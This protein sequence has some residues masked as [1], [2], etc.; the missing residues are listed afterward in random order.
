VAFFASKC[1]QNGGSAVIDV[2]PCF[3][4]VTLDIVCMALFKEKL[5]ALEKMKNGQHANVVE[6]F[7][8]ASSEMTRRI[9]SINPFDWMYGCFLRQKQRKLNKARSLI[10]ER[11]QMIIQRRLKQGIKEKDDDLLKHLLHLTNSTHTGN[12]VSQTVVDNII[13]MM[14]A[15]H[16][17]TANSLSFAIYELSRHQYIQDALRE[18]LVCIKKKYDTEI[19]LAIL[20]KLP[21]L[22]AVMW[23]TL[24]FHPPAL[25]TNRGLVND[26][27]LDNPDGSKIQL[28]KNTGVYFPILAIHR[29]DANWDRPNEYLPSRF[30]DEN[31]SIGG[32]DVKRTHHK[33]ALIPFGGGNRIC[34]GY[35]LSPSEIKVILCEVIQRFKFYP[36]LENGHSHKPT[37]KANGMFMVCTDNQVLVTPIKDKNE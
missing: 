3:Y 9:G 13:T 1:K 23:E 34:P 2:T 26:L 37:I 31:D 32:E 11:I 4:D 19:P 33:F 12:N 17:S 28:E 35:N 14:W 21:I 24:R 16:E 25:W 20:M 8:F 15:G 36:K 7:V 30:L 22:N 29:S 5:G 6:A 18:E 10:Q 27:E